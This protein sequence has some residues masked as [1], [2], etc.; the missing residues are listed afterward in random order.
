MSK[1]NHAYSE[2][3]EKL[4]VISHAFGLVLSILV[5]PFLILKSLYF[6]GFWKPASILVYG[7][8]LIVLYTA[9]TVYHAA[10]DPKIR[11]RL[12][13]FDHAAIYVLIAGTYTPFT[14]IT[15]EG[16]TGWILFIL[17]WTFALIGIILKLFFTGKFDKIST[18]MYVLMGWQIVFAISPLIENL[19]TEGLFWLFT[20]GV[21]YTVGAVL[22][23]IKKIPYNHAIFHVFVLLGSISHFISVYFYC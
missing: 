21:F 13:I 2:K 18:I 15:L 5:F 1:L 9:S 6:E 17:T 20:G 23:S 10:K 16:K 11:R 7:I 4:N 8:S 14:L 19:S 3:E 12:N 22:Y